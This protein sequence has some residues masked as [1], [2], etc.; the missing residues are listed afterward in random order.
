MNFN[1]TVKLVK[2]AITDD[3][4]PCA[5]YAIGNKSEV[6]IKDSIGYRSLYPQKEHITPNTLFDMASLTKILSTSMI[7]FKAIET[8]MI[9]LDD[10]LERFFDECYDKGEVTIRNLLT[11]TS[12]MTAHIPINNMG[13]HDKAIDTILKRKFEYRTGQE[14]IYSCLGFIVLGRILE[15]VYGPSLDDL[16]QSIVFNPLGMN[17][18]MYNPI[19]P[20]LQKPQLTGNSRIDE[21]MSKKPKSSGNKAVIDIAS[22]EYAK[23]INSYLKGKVHD[24]NARSLGGVSGNAGVFS[25]LDDMIKF[26]TM[27]ANNGGGFLSPRMFDAA[28]KNYTEGNIENRGLGFLLTGSKP[29]FA[30]DLFSN[31]SFGH[32]G[33]TGTSIMVDK[34]TGLYVI[35]LTNRVHFG[36]EN[37]RIVKF[38]KLFHNSIWGCL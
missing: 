36:R 21:L 30:G 8:G 16:A 11:H 38:R 37:D 12:G 29:T 3:I 17:S 26:C 22:T 10:K 23:D 1:T 4:F 28:T 15:I 35:L 14:T 13:G 2:Q 19:K 32:T 25:T 27:L 24:E 6:F 31:G 20:P 9:C 7:T 34:A 18:T 33:F 5:A